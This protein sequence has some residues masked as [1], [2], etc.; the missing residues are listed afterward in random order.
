M[1]QRRAENIVFVTANFLSPPREAGKQTGYS[2]DRP[3]HTG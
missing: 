2:K 1:A 3:F